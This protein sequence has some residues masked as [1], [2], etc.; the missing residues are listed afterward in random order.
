[1]LTPSP[2]RVAARAAASYERVFHSPTP[3]T[4]FRA[5]TQESPT[6][7]AKPEGLWYSCGTAWKDWSQRE[8]PSKKY[9][10]TYRIEINPSSMLLIKDK[11][12]FLWFEE[13]YSVQTKYGTPAIDWRK[14][15]R[16]YSGIEICPYRSKQRMDHDWYYGWD[17]ASGCIWAGDAIKSVVEVS[18]GRDTAASAWGSFV[19]PR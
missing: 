5:A 19:G 7:M 14:V 17:V 16:H 10:Y 9:A 15:A 6:L 12:T 8:M 13:K 2:V 18:P 11:A 4:G 3:F 1:M